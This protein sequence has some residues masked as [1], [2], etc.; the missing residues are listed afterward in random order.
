MKPTKRMSGVQRPPT[1]FLLPV[2]DWTEIRLFRLKGSFH[3]AYTTL[4][5]NPRDKKPRLGLCALQ[6]KAHYPKETPPRE[7]GD[8]QKAAE[9]TGVCSSVPHV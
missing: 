5:A 1:A 3:Q 8:V 2:V 6:K 9:A 7:M 4:F